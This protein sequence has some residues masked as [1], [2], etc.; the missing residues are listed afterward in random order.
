M[1]PFLVR[2][3]C[4]LE[5]LGYRDRHYD[6]CRA[7]AEVLGTVLTTHVHTASQGFGIEREAWLAQFTLLHVEIQRSLTEL[8]V[9]EPLPKLRV[10]SAENDCGCMEHLMQRLGHNDDEFSL[11][12]TGKIDRK[13]EQ[14]RAESREEVGHG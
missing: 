4:Q 13:R 5:N 14:E 11:T 12:T 7:A 6:P 8:I 2:G 1:A 10:E 9:F 3:R